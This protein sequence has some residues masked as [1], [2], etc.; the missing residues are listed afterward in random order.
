[1]RN[2]LRGGVLA[3]KVVKRPLIAVA[4][5]GAA[6]TCT[7]SAAADESFEGNESPTFE[8]AAIPLAAGAGKFVFVSGGRDGR[9]RLWEGFGE[10]ARPL[11]VPSAAY[12]DGLDVGTDSRGRPAAVYARCGALAGDPCDLYLFSFAS[13]RERRLR[14][15]RR[16]CRETAP[17]IDRGVV[18]FYREARRS[19]RQSLRCSGGLF[20]KRPARSLRRIARASS[21]GFAVGGDFDYQRGVLAFSRT[22][23]GEE[24]PELGTRYVTELRVRIGGGPSRLLARAA[25]SISRSGTEGTGIGNLELGGGFVYWSRTAHPPVFE[26][27][28]RN[29]VVRTPVRGGPVTLLARAGRLWAT[30]DPAGDD[31]H[32]YDFAVTADELLYR[33]AGSPD[34]QIG[35]VAPRPPAFR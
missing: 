25:E 14:F 16:P 3:F 10:A 20:Q 22:R 11:G 4:L 15:S 33:F 28:R 19:R 9:D 34:A 2:P 24:D 13:G 30:A 27:G 12:I 8:H 23:A 31:L 32:L 18:V 35:R 17:R 5:V 6:L 7:S 26:P 21:G 1:M 29:D